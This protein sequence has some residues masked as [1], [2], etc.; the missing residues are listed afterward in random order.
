MA[1]T[2][3]SEMVR[4]YCIEKCKSGHRRYIYLMGR[5]ATSYTSHY[6]AT[7]ILI[8]NELHG[9]VDCHYGNPKFDPR[10]ATIAEAIDW[11]AS[12]YRE[13]GCKP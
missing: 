2:D 12:M 3:L 7:L 10:L 4:E 8:Q 5:Y 13:I 1:M 9:N 11:P 6:I